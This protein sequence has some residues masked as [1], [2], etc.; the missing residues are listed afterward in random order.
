MN[1]HSIVV[2]DD[3]PIIREGISKIINQQKDMEVVG[4]AV[5]VNEAIKI[6]KKKNPDMAIVDISLKDSNGIDLIKEVK[7]KI[8]TLPIL[9]LSM[10]PE[11]LYAERVLRAGARG[12]IMK[13]EPPEKIIHAIRK[14]LEGKIYLS[15]DISEK[16]LSGL[17][18]V[19]PKDTQSAI[20]SLSDREL[21]VFRLIGEGFKPHQIADQLFLS[22]KTVETYTFRLKQKLNLDSASELRL[23]A[24]KWLQKEEKA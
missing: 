15:E 22:V 1:K 4:E 16:I 2:V 12:Y 6:L 13:H 5:N 9:V 24:I 17:T 8:G 21:E 10:H 23:F 20:G 19:T 7:S 3:H 11:T 18:G 14:V